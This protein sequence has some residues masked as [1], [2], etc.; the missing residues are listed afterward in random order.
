NEKQ[1][2]ANGEDGNDGESHNRSWNCGVEGP[3]KDKKVNALR[4]RQQRNML[5][6]LL[7]SQGVPMLLHGDE[8]GRSQGGNNNGYCQDNEISWIDWDLDQDQLDLIAFTQRLVELRREHPVFRRRRFFAGSADHGGESA[9]GDIAWFEPGGNHMDEDSWANGYA[10]AMM[11]FLNGQTIPEPDTRGQQTLDDHF[12]VIFNGHHD[13]LPFVVP[14]KEY[15][16]RW[17]TELDTSAQEVGAKEYKP[18]AKVKAQGRSVIVLRCPRPLP[19][20]SPAGA[21]VARR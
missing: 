12:L 6:T 3:T 14:S 2:D 20:G 17:V 16:D 5:A 10:R 19:S 9:V 15:G 21:A 13:V 4:L 7:L 11:V 18:D 8:L 1:N